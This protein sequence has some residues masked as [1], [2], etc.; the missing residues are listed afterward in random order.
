[1]NIIWG[2]GSPP[3]AP[4]MILSGAYRMISKFFPL[5]LG[6]YMFKCL[7]HRQSALLVGNSSGSELYNNKLLQFLNCGRDSTLEIILFSKVESSATR[8]IICFF[9]SRITFLI[10]DFPIIFYF[11]GDWEFCQMFV[12]CF[13]CSVN[14]IIIFVKDSI[15]C[16]VAQSIL[17]Y[18]SL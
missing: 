18:Q 7:L 12:K 14:V 8:G 2:L 1:M 15:E 16:I 6:R 11:F 13:Y 9:N 4:D 5:T 10:S 3:N 17:S